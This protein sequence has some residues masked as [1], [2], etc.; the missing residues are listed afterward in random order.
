MKEHTF[1]Y[2]EYIKSI[3]GDRNQNNGSFLGKG[4]SIKSRVG[5]I[6]YTDW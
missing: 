6:L 1:H 2:S 4:G 5:N 3:Y